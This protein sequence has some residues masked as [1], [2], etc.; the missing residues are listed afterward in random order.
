MPGV[1][2]C[3]SRARAPITAAL[4]AS[5]RGPSSA[6]QRAVRASVALATTAGMA[7]SAAVAATVRPAS[8]VRIGGCP[9]GMMVR[10]GPA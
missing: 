4:G 10:P 2:S 3:L 1:G 9:P 8:G 5:E 6:A 7:Q